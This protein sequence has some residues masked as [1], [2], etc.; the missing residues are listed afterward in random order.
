LVV[1]VVSKTGLAG[2]LRASEPEPSAHPSGGARD[3]ASVGLRSCPGDK[4]ASFFEKKA[5]FVHREAKNLYAA[6]ADP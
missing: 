4:K 3:C 5:A 2:F 6:V 1:S